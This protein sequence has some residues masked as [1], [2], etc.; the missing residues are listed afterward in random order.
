MSFSIRRANAADFESICD[1]VVTLGL[2]S[3]RSRI[4]NTFD[5]SS[6]W[7]AESESGSIIGCVGLEHGEQASLL[8]SAAVLPASQGVGIGRALS[9]TAIQ[10]ARDQGYIAL[11]LFS[12]DAGPYWQKFGFNLVPVDELVRALP[13]LPQ[14]R[15]GIERG[16]LAE[17]V[18]WTLTL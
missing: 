16:W 8:R 18:A 6:Y 5:G 2:I 9:A 1:L 7:V 14:V 11:Y 17:E 4:T 10:S 13:T 15:S 12:T 3:E